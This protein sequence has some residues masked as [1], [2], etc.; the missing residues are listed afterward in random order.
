MKSCSTVFSVLVFAALLTA[1]SLH[2]QARQTKARLRV[3]A[4]VVHS[5]QIAGAAESVTLSCASARGL[6]PRLTAQD[7]LGPVTL[8]QA[9]DASFV[10]IP[11][12]IAVETPDPGPSERYARTR[13]VTVTVRF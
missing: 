1:G 8:Y 3:T 12:P 9:E 11:D 6:Q 5:C 2:A 10:V 13:A 7:D 4:T